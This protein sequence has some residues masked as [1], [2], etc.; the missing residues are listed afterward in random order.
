MSYLMAHTEIVFLPHYD[1]GHTKIFLFKNSTEKSPF[2]YE[3]WLFMT[4]DNEVNRHDQST[5]IKWLCKEHKR[6][7]ELV[8]GTH[9]VPDLKLCGLAVHGDNA[10]AKLDVV[11]GFIHRLERLIRELQAQAGFPDTCNN[12]SP[13][14]AIQNVKGAMFAGRSYE[15][16][17]IEVADNS[18]DR[19]DLGRRRLCTWSS[20]RMSSPIADS[21]QAAGRSSVW[22]GEAGD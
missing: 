6:D 7:I 17:G 21:R 13:T 12:R 18:R 19:I 8:D 11:G 3:I 5:L 2:D 9:R 22:I 16:V 20:D 10:R 1:M 14:A 4:W 15:T